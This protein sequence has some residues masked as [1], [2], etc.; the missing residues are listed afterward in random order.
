MA[1]IQGANKRSLTM[2]EWSL[3]LNYLLLT[4][5]NGIA[6]SYSVVDFFSF[7]GPLRSPNAVLVSAL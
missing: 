1:T 3:A 2:D 7:R 6:P 4:F 5:N